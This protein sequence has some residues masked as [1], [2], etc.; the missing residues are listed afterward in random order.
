MAATKVAEPSSRPSVESQHIT[1]APGTFERIVWRQK[2]FQPGFWIERGERIALHLL[3]ISENGVR[4]HSARPPAMGESVL[5]H[6]DLP[7]GRAIVRWVSAKTFGLE[8]VVPLTSNTVSAILQLPP[9]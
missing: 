8:F 4:A 3:D 1:L 6:C 9:R 5:V 7:L 2:S